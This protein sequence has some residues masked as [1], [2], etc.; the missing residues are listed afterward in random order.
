[1]KLSHG[2]KDFCGRRIFLVGAVWISFR[3][4]AILTFAET[5]IKLK[6]N[7]LDLRQF[8]SE[9]MV[10]EKIFESQTTAAECAK[11][12]SELIFRNINFYIGIRCV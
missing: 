5:F 7:A 1:M 9:K 11:S 3:E 8:W 12:R 6:Y 10:L 4:S 2:L